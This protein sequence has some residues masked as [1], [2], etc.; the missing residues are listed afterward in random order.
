MAQQCAL[1]AARAFF[2][3]R[4]LVAA[5]ALALAALRALVAMRAVHTLVAEC[6]VHV[7]VVARA[8]ALRRR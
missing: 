5:R 6:E 7:L 3:A 1:F 4:A 2:A 8:L